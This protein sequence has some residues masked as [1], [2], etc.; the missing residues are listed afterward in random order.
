MPYVAHMHISDAIGLNGEGIQIFEGELNFKSTFD[1]VKN[2]DF[3]WVTEI[4]SG[5][6]HNGCGT[7]KALCDLETIYSKLL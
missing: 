2:Y 6:L 1:I 3:S 5:H 4:W 7:Y